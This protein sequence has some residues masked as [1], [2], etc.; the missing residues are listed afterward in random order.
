MCAEDVRAIH[1]SGG[2]LGIMMDKGLLGTKV[3]LQKISAIKDADQQ[4][5]TYV[6]LIWDNIFEAI[7]AVGQKSAWD[8]IALGTDYDGIITHIDHYP[9]LANMMDLKQDLIT[10]LT[11][12][13]YQEKFWFGYT[14]QELVHKMMHQN[15]IEVLKKYFMNPVQQ[16]TPSLIFS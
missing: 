8:I 15:T 9:N 6:K 3:L 2:L 12:T 10:Y 5:Q 16:V 7:K 11:D 4:K 13:A 14:P 1:D